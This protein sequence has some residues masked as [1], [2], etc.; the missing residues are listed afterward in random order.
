[1]VLDGFDLVV[2][3]AV[4]PTLLKTHELGFDP[5]GAT[6]AAT[7]SLVGVGLGALFIAPLSDRF[8]RRRLLIACVAWFSV[9]TLAVVAAPNVALF[10]AFR[11]LA[12][13]GLGACLPAALA[14]INDYAKAGSGAS[15]TTRTMTGY[16]AGA[17]ATAF[18]ALVIMP[19]W[20]AMFI[21]GGI[22]GLVLLPFLWAKLPESL[23]AAPEATPAAGSAHDAGDAPSSSAAPSESAAAAGRA[24]KAG[25]R[26]LLRK[27]YPL[28]ALGI[29]VAS[30]MGLLLVYGLNTWLPT[31]MAEAGYSMSSSLTLL[32]VLNVGAVAGLLVAGWLAD[33]HG[34]KRIV[35]LWFG[36]S[37]VL[38]AA[39]SFRMQNELLLNAAVFVTGVFVFSAQVLV[40]AWVSQLFPAHLRGTALGFSAGVGRMGA[41]LGP[42]VTGT[43]V[44][45]GVAYPWGFY[46]FAAAAV[47]AVLALMALPHA[48]QSRQEA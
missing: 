12:G 40:Y 26:S 34:T 19:D 37:A 45:L 35:L 6:L 7:I 22:A 48:V 36:V 47:L 16:H 25:F 28:V 14:Y 42:A 13:L 4:I 5:V 27:P 31:L 18:L 20:R 32:L 38:L 30:F 1:M 33:K 24:E 17:V 9:F 10:S 21:A 39:L 29:A 46:V 3:G 2:L 44:T 41:I 8:G 43:L 11:L 15:N 23:P